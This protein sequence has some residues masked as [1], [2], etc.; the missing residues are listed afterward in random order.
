MRTVF[1]LNLLELMKANK[2]KYWIKLH[3]YLGLIPGIPLLLIGLTGVLLAFA[4]QIQRWDQPQ[5]YD[6]RTQGKQR[7]MTELVQKIKKEYP[8][9]R[10]NHISIF[11]EPDRPWTVFATGP[12]N[13]K[14]RFHRMHVD[15]YTGAISL[16]ITDGGW[17]QWIEELHRNLTIGTAGRYIVAI[18]SIFLIVLSLSGLYLWLPLRVGSWNRLLTRGDALSWH[19]WTGIIVFP[20]LILMAFTGI[21]LTFGKTIMPAVYDVTGSPDLPPE[22][23]SS[24]PDD[25]VQTVTLADAITR[26]KNERPDKVI[27]GV[28]EPGSEDG[29]YIIHWGYE[30]DINPH[31]WGK[32]FVDQYSGQIIGEIDNYKHSAG[33][34]YQQT[35]WMLHT[36]EFFGTSGRIIWALGS[37]A[38][39]LLFVTGL[40]RWLGKN[41]RKKRIRSI[42]KPG[43]D[44][45]PEGES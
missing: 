30:D 35:W 12:V 9:T 15:P 7:P 11:E 44:R 28:G 20:M 27:T 22:P 26:F 8:D 2:R 17:A 45:G 32:T 33:S 39:P 37:L 34:I 1:S 40:F 36:G 4:P 19:N 14:H 13:G 41:G 3:L 29:V 10:L 38:L 5:F 43:S 23:L 18:S 42:L 16:D 24:V 6:I 25:S 21:T 31:A